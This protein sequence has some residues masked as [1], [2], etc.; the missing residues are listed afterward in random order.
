MGE[1]GEDGDEEGVTASAVAEH[2]LIVSDGYIRIY[3]CATGWYQQPELSPIISLC[4]PYFI[5]PPS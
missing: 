4:M 1:E 5:P 3:R 2:I